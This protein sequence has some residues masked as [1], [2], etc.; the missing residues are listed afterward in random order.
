MA[1]NR[2]LLLMK[3]SKSVLKSTVKIFGGCFVFLV[4]G[5]GKVNSPARFC[6]ITQSKKITGIEKITSVSLLE[7]PIMT[8]VLSRFQPEVIFYMIILQRKVCF[9]SHQQ[10]GISK[11]NSSGEMDA[12]FRE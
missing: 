1:E 8:L 11:K 10:F 7:S 9:K 4:F 2:L 12:N 6:F 5:K 3:A